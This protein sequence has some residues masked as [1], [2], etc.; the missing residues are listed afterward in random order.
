MTRSHGKEKVLLHAEGPLLELWGYS[1][2]ER[3]PHGC[4][5]SATVHHGCFA[6][7][8]PSVVVVSPRR[9]EIIWKIVGA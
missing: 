3:K 7:A 2:T 4:F 1:V 6:D 9:V 5:V 8:T